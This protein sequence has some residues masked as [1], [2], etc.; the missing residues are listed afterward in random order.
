MPT[1]PTTRQGRRRRAQVR[2]GNARQGRRA[3]TSTASC[4]ASTC[5]RT[6]S[7]R[8]V[9]GGFGFCDVV[10]GWDSHGLS[11]TT[12]R[13][14]PAG[15]TASRTRWRG[16]TSTPARRVPW[17]DDVPFFLGEFVNADGSAVPGLPAPDAEARARSAP[18]SSASRRC[19]GMEFE[20][21]NFAETPQSWAA[22]KGVG[23]DADH[24]GHVRL[25]AAAHERQP[26]ASSTR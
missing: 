22:K 1:P 2:R 11:A 3:A 19:A 15:S 17:D 13:R 24:A 18:R 6:S 21:F 8:A 23:P 4:A 14:S 16:S 9:D 7:S 26:R 20:W 25:L 12:T 10:F 5:T